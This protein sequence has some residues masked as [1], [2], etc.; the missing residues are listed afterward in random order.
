VQGPGWVYS[1]DGRQLHA[2]RGLWQISSQWW[3]QYGDATVDDPYQAARLVYTISKAGTDF[4]P[5]DTY[6]GGAAQRHW[7]NAVDGW[8]ALRPEVQAFLRN[9]GASGAVASASVTSGTSH[10]VAWDG[11]LWKIARQYYGD[12]DLWP[13]L[14]AANGV[15]VPE[16]L[17][18]GTVLNIP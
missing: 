4:N 1:G 17:H 9:R 12:G 8:P 18:P 14:A 6:R 2:D 11:T 5:W 10:T 3:P 16:Q 15:R 7:D 13:R